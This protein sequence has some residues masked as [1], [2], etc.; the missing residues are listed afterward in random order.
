MPRNIY[1]SIEYT[2]ACGT[3]IKYL[4]DD[5][6]PPTPYECDACKLE[7]LEQELNELAAMDELRRS[8]IDLERPIERV[9]FDAQW[10]RKVDFN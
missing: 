4:R 1:G 7:A 9:N 8:F 10:P 2:C 3:T 5:F 6:L